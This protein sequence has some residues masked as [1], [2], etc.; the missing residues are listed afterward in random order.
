MSIFTLNKVKTLSD[1]YNRFQKLLNALK[2]YG[3]VYS[4]KDTNL[5]FLRSLPKEWKAYDRIPL[6]HSHEFM[7]YNLEKTILVS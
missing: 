2:L 4:I 5:K 6:I 1:T 3:R 7:D